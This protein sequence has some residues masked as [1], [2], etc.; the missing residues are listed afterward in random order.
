MAQSGHAP[1]GSEFEQLFEAVGGQVAEVAALLDVPPIEVTAVV[2]DDF[3][4]EVERA[5]ASSEESEDY[6]N[7]RYNTDRLGSLA[8]AQT[9]R[10]TRDASRCQI[11]FDRTRLNLLGDPLTSLK[12]TM[13]VAHEMAHPLFFRLRAASGA[14]EASDGPVHPVDFARA[15]TR[16]AA[17]EMR[18]DIVADV[19][20][21]RM[22]SLSTPDGQSRPATIADAAFSDGLRISIGEVLDETIYPGWPDLVDKCLAQEV[23]LDHLWRTVIYQT[24]EML[25]LLAYAQVPARSADIPGPLEAEYAEHPGTRLYLSSTWIRILDAAADTLIVPLDRFRDCE[26][27]LVTVGEAAL[28][29]MWERVG[30]TFGPSHS[31]SFHIYVTKPAR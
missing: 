22:A 2:A 28:L 31:N 12:T 20:L 21:Q 5:R 10:L 7:T 8:V 16:N 9:T 25:N 24:A 6:G 26:N 19:V 29:N 11:V 13:F 17:D 3:R 18:C 27:E 14:V 4:G 23:S 30:L 1:V 15:I